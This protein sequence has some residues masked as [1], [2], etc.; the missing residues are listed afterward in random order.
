LVERRRRPRRAGF[1]RRPAGGRPLDA[2]RPPGKR[3]VRARSCGT[4][5]G[6]PVGTFGAAALWSAPHMRRRSV[7][8]IAALIAVLALAALPV[9]VGSRSPSASSAI[10][11]AAFRTLDFPATLSGISVPAVQLDPA[12]DSAGS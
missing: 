4:A 5:R 7:V 3:C 9:P 11:P 8:A 1:G 10:E 12:L 2:L 6:T